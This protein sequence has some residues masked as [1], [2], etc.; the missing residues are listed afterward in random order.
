MDYTYNIQ[1]WLLQTVETCNGATTTA[2][3]TYDDNGNQETV[4]ESGPSG[5]L[6]STYEY[7]NFNQLKTAQ[8]PDGEVITSKYDASGMRIEKTVNGVTTTYKF[9]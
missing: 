7:D 1:N 9:V 4:T 8:T 2:A 5:I 3:L 6:V